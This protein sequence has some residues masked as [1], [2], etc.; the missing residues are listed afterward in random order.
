MLKCSEELLA[1][2]DE[3]NDNELNFTD[4]AV[5]DNHESA[6]KELESLGKIRV[7]HSVTGKITRI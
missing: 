3:Y 1:L 6:I 5:I 7:D 4:Y 2:F